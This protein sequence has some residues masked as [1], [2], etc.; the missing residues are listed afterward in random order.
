MNHEDLG[1]PRLTVQPLP[2]LHQHAGPH[3]PLRAHRHRTPHA[4]EQAHHVGR[5]A[6]FGPV[7]HRRARQ[8]R[9]HAVDAV[10]PPREER[11]Q[12]PEEAAHGV[13]RGCIGGVVGRVDLDHASAALCFSDVEIGSTDVGEHAGEEDEGF[14]C[15]GGGGGGG[16]L[17]EELGELGGVGQADGVDVDGGDIGGRGVGGG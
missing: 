5:A 10:A 6:P 3:R 4:L 1:I 2:F 14:G 16:E 11:T 9:C 13:L 17:E 15:R 8:P 12:V 7:R